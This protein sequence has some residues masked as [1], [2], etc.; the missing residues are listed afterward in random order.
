MESRKLAAVAIASGVFGGTAGVLATAAT[1]SQANP[2][3]I[4]AAVQKVQDSSADRSLRSIQSSLGSI[5]SSLS[6]VAAN[7]HS[8]RS[9]VYAADYRSAQSAWL[10]TNALDLWLQQICRNTA[11]NG[12]CQTVSFPTG[13]QPPPFIP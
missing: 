5:A 3:A 10:E 1:Q 13:P 2:E 6:T 9:D 12:F 7:T 4:A 11:P 8:L